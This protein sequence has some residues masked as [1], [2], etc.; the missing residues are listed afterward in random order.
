MGATAI[1][2]TN[3]RDADH[4]HSIGDNWDDYFFDT[5]M[6]FEVGE[7]R[8]SALALSATEQKEIKVGAFAEA[9]D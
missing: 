4:S 3:L 5:G 6:M 8:F 1:T 7:R 2:W 9:G